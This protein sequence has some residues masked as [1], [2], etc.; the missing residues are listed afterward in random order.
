MRIMSYWNRHLLSLNLHPYIT[1]ESCSSK[2]NTDC[3]YVKRI[4]CLQEAKELSLLRVHPRFNLIIRK[5]SWCAF[6]YV[7]L[8]F[9][10]QSLTQRHLQRVKSAFKKVTPSPLQVCVEMSQGINVKLLVGRERKKVTS[11]QEMERKMKNREEGGL[12]LW[13]LCSLPPWEQVCDASNS[14]NVVCW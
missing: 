3:C 2:N 7:C 11:Q 9:S 8:C 10:S 14:Y 5:M 1:H 6:T 13:N 4:A 12:Q